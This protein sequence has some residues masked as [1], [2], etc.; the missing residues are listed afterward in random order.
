MEKNIS[1]EK[2]N[3]NTK[4][5]PNSI[6]KPVGK[7]ASVTKEEIL[8]V[9]AD[10]KGLVYR[11]LKSTGLSSS[12]F[13]RWIKEDPEFAKAVADTE[14]I[15]KD[16]AR[17]K[18]AEL[19]DDGNPQAIIFY[20]RCKNGFVET[21]KVEATVNSNDTIDVNMALKQIKDELK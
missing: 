7:K 9:L 10:N 18:L 16:Y 6:F 8:Q 14:Q 20:N 15:E 17:C 5:E 3:R 19:I 12:A 11:A 21:K 4:S 2:L 1:P 13:Y